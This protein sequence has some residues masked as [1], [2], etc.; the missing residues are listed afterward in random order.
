MLKVYY[1]DDEE[2]LIDMFIDY[3]DTGQI[4]LKTFQSPEEAIKA[5]E[6]SPP[7][8][9]FIDFQMPSMNGDQVAF[10]IDERIPIILIT[11]DIDQKYQYD[12]KKVI[13]KPYQVHEVQ[14]IIEEYQKK[15][16][17]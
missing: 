11:G 14:E 5:V 2:L 3:F 1:L 4:N 9:L 16:P 8:L 12:F 15:N 13:R 6:D 17:L 7:D 10:A